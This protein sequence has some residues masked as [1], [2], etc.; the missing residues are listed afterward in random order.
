MY[1]L[2]VSILNSS[3]RKANQKAHNILQYRMFALIKT[4]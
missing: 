1:I 2:Q 3:Y 4:K